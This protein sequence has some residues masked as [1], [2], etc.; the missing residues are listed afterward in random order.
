MKEK[1]DPYKH[2]ERYQAWKEKVKDGIPNISKESSDLTK[3]KD[4]LE[5]EKQKGSIE[6]EKMKKETDF[7]RE[8]FAKELEERKKYDK[9]LNKI[10]ANPKIMVMIGK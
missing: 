7:I 6:L 8:A 9:I 2:K 3:M 1:I 4:E 10:I 5:K